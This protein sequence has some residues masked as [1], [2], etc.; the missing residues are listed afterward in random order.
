M[1]R[2]STGART[3]DVPACKAGVLTATLWSHILALLLMLQVKIFTKYMTLALL[4]SPEAS[5]TLCLFSYLIQPHYL[6]FF[7]EYHNSQ[8]VGPLHMLFLLPRTLSL[9][10]VPTHSSYCDTEN[11]SIDPRPDQIP[12]FTTVLHVPTTI[13]KLTPIND[14]DLVNAC[15]IPRLGALSVLPTIASPQCLAQSLAA[16]RLSVKNLKERKGKRKVGRNG[17]G[18][19]RTKES[20][21]LCLSLIH[22]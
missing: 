22:I 2:G 17:K 3:Q 6:S 8:H 21:G 9:P 7:T 13:C 10:L 16:K 12:L 5:P 20:L 14:C 15:P 1:D 18:R 4:T 19:T 11:L